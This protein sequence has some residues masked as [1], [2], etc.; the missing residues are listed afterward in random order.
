MNLTDLQV[1]LRQLGDRLGQLHREIEKMKPKSEDEQQAAFASI[2]KLA[3]QAPLQHTTLLNADPSIKKTFLQ[4]LAYLI[5]SAGQDVNAR[6]LYLCRLA[7]GISCGPDPEASA[8]ALYKAGLEFQAEDLLDLAHLPQ[9]L[10][11]IF[12]VEALIAAH[13]APESA[14][15]LYAAVADAAEIMQ[16]DKEELRVCAAV[17]KGRLL[18]NY[19]GLDELPQPLRHKWSDLFADYIPQAWLGK[20]RLK[21][22]ELVRHSHLKGFFI[23]DNFYSLDGENESLD[24]I[25]TISNALDPGESVQPEQIILTYQQKITKTKKRNIGWFDYEYVPTTTTDQHS[26]EAPRAGIVFYATT[27]PNGELENRPNEDTKVYVVSPFDTYE[28]FSAWI[29]EGGDKEDAGDSEK[30]GGDKEDAGDS[31][32]RWRC[33][34][35]CD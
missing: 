20:R 22:A 21:C 8:E 4:S 32:C 11:Y 26:V 12:V 10:K 13:T 7:L 14:P 34:Q 18:D 30:E 16:C 28:A 31:R 2:N 19:D 6:L 5:V 27:N 3:A 17:A 24:Q 35:D 9:D 25:I 29:K 23:D 15:A 1:E 33:V